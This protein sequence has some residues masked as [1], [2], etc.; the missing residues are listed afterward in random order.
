MQTLA[1][2]LT[3]KATPSSAL[4]D[5]LD[6]DLANAQSEGDTQFDDVMSRA[7]SPQTKTTD[8]LSTASQPAKTAADIAKKITPLN[9]SVAANA[10]PVLASA[11][12][13]ETVKAT[14][15][16]SDGDAKKLSDSDSKTEKKTATDDSLAAMMNPVADANPQNLTIQMLAPSLSSYLLGTTDNQ[17][18]ASAKATVSDNQNSVAPVIIG[19]AMKSVVAGK[20]TKA[21]S[22]AGKNISDLDSLAATKEAL[23]E[24]T[25]AT[26]QL[27]A[28]SVATPTGLPADLKSAGQKLNLTAVT[29]SPDKM[30]VQP[31]SSKA[32]TK[33]EKL[34]ALETAADKIAGSVLTASSTNETAVVD[35]TPENIDVSANATPS[36]PVKAHGTVAAKQDVPMKKADNTIKVAGQGEK[37][38]PGGSVSSAHQSNLTVRA[39][40][41]ASAT[42]RAKTAESNIVPLSS[43]AA[44]EASSAGSTV[45]NVSV[46]NLEELRARAVDRT[47]DMVALQSVR[48]VDSQTDSLSVVIKPGAGVQLSL[49][50]KQGSDGIEAQAVLQQGDFQDLNQRWPELQ[51]RLEQRGIKLAPLTSDESAMSFTGQNSSRQNQQ[52][53]EEKALYA[54]A[55]AEFSMAGFMSTPT[56]EP[57]IAALARGGWQSW[58]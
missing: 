9:L 10:V 47:H 15:T 30:E 46:P 34:S 43:L 45:A 52:P 41:A 4:K 25:A 18:S 55:F 7:L 57:A 36:A 37:V 23:P 22:V 48:L 26:S 54:S 16:D 14:A 32:A 49:Q 20:M 5:G 13:T 44:Q 17:P 53:A 31:I 21:E 8:T 40:S 1:Q 29:E 12:E 50:L 24:P 11:D 27:E 33:E 38:L 39:I 6:A 2:I 3:A 56:A 51:Q 28:G 35:K 42:S 58:A 19:E